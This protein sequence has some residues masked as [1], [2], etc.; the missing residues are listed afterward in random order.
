MNPGDIVRVTGHTWNGFTIE[1][2]GG[3]VGF[4]LTPH[5][6]TSKR[7]EIGTLLEVVE[8]S[9]QDLFLRPAASS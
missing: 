9:Y 2:V 8:L 7:P 3:I 6:S 5:D 1:V 4:N